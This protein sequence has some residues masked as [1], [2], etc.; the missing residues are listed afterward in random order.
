M[1]GLAGKGWIVCTH[2]TQFTGTAVGAID[3]MYRWVSK[4]EQ[5]ACVMMLCVEGA[6]AALAV[7]AEGMQQCNRAE[8]GS[9]P[10]RC[11]GS[12]AIG[13]QAAQQK[14]DVLIGKQGRYEHNTALLLMLA[15]SCAAAA[16]ACILYLQA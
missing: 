7:L 4:G 15:S 16:A 14:Q 2:S 10:L 6:A 13:T 12:S 5:L 1:C 3:C 8:Q 9:L 11:N